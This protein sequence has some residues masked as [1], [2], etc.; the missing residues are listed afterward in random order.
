MGGYGTLLDLADRLDRDPSADHPDYLA[1]LRDGHLAVASAGS[2]RR[3][4]ARDRH[5]RAFLGTTSSR[6]RRADRPCPPPLQLSLL[7]SRA[8][9][10]GIPAPLPPPPRAELEVSTRRF[11]LPGNLRCWNLWPKANRTPRSVGKL[12]ISASLAKLEVTF[13][14][15]ALGAK[16]RLDAVVQAKPSATGYCPRHPTLVRPTNKALRGRLLGR[17]A[18]VFVE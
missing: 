10:S 2:L 3:Y 5:L 1:A 11:S 13:L 17:D 18:A 9:V 14:M 7:T 4:S 6:Y 8:C 15:H 16:N 12:S